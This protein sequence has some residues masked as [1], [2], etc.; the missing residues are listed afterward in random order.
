ME[1]HQSE[2]QVYETLKSKFGDKTIS[3]HTLRL[4]QKITNAQS[5]Y[6]FS[7]LDDQ[8]AKTKSEIRL[9]KNDILFATAIGYGVVAVNMTA[10]AVDSRDAKAEIAT[11]PNQVI[12]LVA[13]GFDPTDLEVFWKSTL[14]LKVGDTE[15]IPGMETDI[16][17]FAPRTQ[18][19]AATNYD[20]YDKNSG[21]YKVP[22]YYTLRGTDEIKF[23]VSAPYYTGIQVANT[24]ANF[25]NRLVLRL[26]GFLIR[27]GATL[28]V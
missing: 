8:S 16:F 26:R 12:F 24:N 19:S 21:F 13:A 6:S 11:Y 23:Q 15:F 2:R 9:N 25:E 7:T 3:P 18:K 27:G 14:L 5:L 10:A 1:N 28:T 20:Q 22:T 4:E 17:R